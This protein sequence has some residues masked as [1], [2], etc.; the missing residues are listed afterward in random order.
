M[1][2]ALPLQTLLGATPD[3][4]T[5][6]VPF[7]MRIHFKCCLFLIML[8][9]CAHFSFMFSSQLPGFRSHINTK[10]LNIVS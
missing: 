6:S 9:I 4:K 3:L 10:I 7:F 5:L 8:I 1:H 2:E